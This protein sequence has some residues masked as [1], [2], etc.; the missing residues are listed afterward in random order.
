MQF[1]SI[2]NFNQFK[3]KYNCS[4]SETHAFLLGAMFRGPSPDGILSTMTPLDIY[5][6]SHKS[7]I[8]NVSDHQ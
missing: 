7:C 8:I 3:E 6:L 5:K 1:T 4:S 2:Y